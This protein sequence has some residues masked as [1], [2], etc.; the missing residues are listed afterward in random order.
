MVTQGSLYIMARLHPIKPCSQKTQVASVSGLPTESQSLAANIP[1]VSVAE[2]QDSEGPSVVILDQ[3]NP[4]CGANIDF[5]SDASLINEDIIQS[6]EGVSYCDNQV[7]SNEHGTTTRTLA[8]ILQGIQANINRQNVSLINVHRSTFWEDTCHQL[9]G[10]KFSP[11]NRLSVKFVNNEGESE[12]AVDLGGPTR[13]FLTLA[14]KAANEESG[15]FIGP[16]ECRSLF[17]NTT[18]RD[19]DLYF[20]VGMVLACS[21][22]HGGPGGNFFSTT[23]YN[24]LAYGPYVKPPRLEDV[25]NQELKQKISRVCNSESAEELRNNLE[26]EEIREILDAQGFATLP[27]LKKKDYIA[28]IILRHVL[29]DSTRSHFEELKEG[30]KANGVLEAIQAH[31]EK[32]RELFTQKDVLPLDSGTMEAIFE[33]HYAEY[34]SDQRNHQE[35]TVGY[36]RDYLQDCENGNAQAT[37]GDVLSFATGAS[38]PPYLGFE[39]FPVINFTEQRFPSANTCALVLKLPT[40]FESYDEFKMSMDYGILNSRCFGQV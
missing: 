15:I 30:L 4:Q 32:L 26:D 34:G 14:V 11:N 6:D 23:L 13:E 5:R 21:L 39:S 1:T 17:P 25:P 2:K 9:G 37:L 7:I 12:G 20:I 31:P 3:D 10:K 33:I 35:R 22:A 36:W 38:V 24:S 18:A 8:E 29:V 28:S 19:K 16:P 27:L 40:I